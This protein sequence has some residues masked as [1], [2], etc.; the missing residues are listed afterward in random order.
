MYNSTFT[1][2]SY[3]QFLIAYSFPPGAHNIC[4]PLSLC[5]HLYKHTGRHFS[6]C[7]KPNSLAPPTSFLLLKSWLDL[8]LGCPL[9][10]P[11]MC[12]WAK[13]PLGTSD[14][15]MVQDIQHMYM[16]IGVF[17]I[18]YN[19]NLIKPPVWNFRRGYGYFTQI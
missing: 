18:I 1:F 6:S 7:F 9:S 17:K 4:A 19:R 14:D 13:S 15:A 10:L 16:C 12:Q 11:V 8:S 5:S 2:P 3:E